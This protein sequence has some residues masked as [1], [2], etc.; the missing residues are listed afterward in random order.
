MCSVG[1]M[2]PGLLASIVETAS[3]AIFLID[4]NDTIVH[5]NG[6]AME[7][8]RLTPK[9]VLGVSLSKITQTVDGH[10]VAH[11]LRQVRAREIV[12]LP[13]AIFPS[14]DATRCGESFQTITGGEQSRYIALVAHVATRQAEPEEQRDPVTGLFTRPNVP[15]IIESALSRSS[16]FGS[17][18]VAVLFVMLHGFKNV[19]QLHGHRIGDLLLENTGVRIREMLRKSDFVFRWEGTNLVVLLPEI[20]TRLDGMLVAEKLYDSIKIPYRVRETD[21]TPGCHIGI[22]IYPDDGD[23][24]ETLIDCANSAVIEAERREEPFRYFDRLTHAQANERLELKTA[25]QRAFEN[26]EFELFYQP[27]V[28]PNGSIAGAEALIRWNH[29]ERGL[30]GPISFIDLA[31]DTRL[32]TPI[33][34][35]AL[36]TVCRVINDPQ[37]PE[38]FFITF[39]VSAL[40]FIDPA[41]PEVV[42]QAIVEANL[43]PSKRIVVEVT[44][45]RAIENRSNLLLAIDKIQ[46]LGSRCGW[47]ISVR[48]NPHSAT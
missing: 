31:E 48:G 19:N 4:D 33:D 21:I 27:V 26:D 17:Y 28:R 29:P 22:A 34:K 18:P 47:T 8:C 36:Y 32:I 44:E 12:Q 5:A 45:S 6:R 46:Q 35:L 13:T 39:N 2:D 43:S 23:D 37:I 24:G 20:T 10:S 30:L 41:F 42:S 38:D 14:W 11:I 25:I 15:P 9:E 7:S 16:R 1:D 3:D 40:N